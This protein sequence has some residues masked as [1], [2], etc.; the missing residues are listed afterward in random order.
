[1]QTEA[2]DVRIAV[3]KLFIVQVAFM[4]YALLGLS[5]GLSAGL[6]PGP[7]L[8]L[9]IQRSL[10]SGL[11]SGLR[12]AFAP[13][14]SDL[15]IVALS[16]LV[17]SRLPSRALGGMLIIGGC[18]VLWLAIDAWRT[19]HSGEDNATSASPQQDLLHAAL[20][21]FLNPHPYLF[22]LAVGAPTATVAWQSNPA[23]AVLF[24][25]LF[26]LLLIGSKIVLAFLFSRAHR[27]PPH[28]HRQ[29][30]RASALLLVAA[31]VYMFASAWHYIGG[32]L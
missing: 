10:Q 19:G 23:Y 25:G 9:V 30:T 3:T 5:L 22:W 21:N 26:Y 2:A 32:T 15:P 31:A 7:L 16:F 29:L 28:R 18:F 27:L 4:P 1:M 11:S 13:L 12:V 8:A 17:V 20:V 14:I 24:V 6:A